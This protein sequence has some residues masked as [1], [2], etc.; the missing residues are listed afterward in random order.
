M[1][2]YGIDPGFTGAIA[3]YAPNTGFF[4]VYDMPTMLNSKG[5]VELNHFAVL[6]ILEKE[7]EVEHQAW[8]EKVGAMPG[9]GVSS[10]CFA[11]ASVWISGNGNCSV[12]LRDPLRLAGHLEEA[13]HDHIKQRRCTLN[14]NAA[15]PRT[16]RE[17]R[18]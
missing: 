3:V 17:V 9:Q 16:C 7:M 6:N 8:I 13:L 10:V 18:P 5:K 4:D 14:C 1:I 2:F 12:R 15:F 11:S